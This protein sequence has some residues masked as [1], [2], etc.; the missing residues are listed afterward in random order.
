MFKRKLK[1]PLPPPEWLVVGLGNPGPEYAGTRHNVG[2]EVVELLANEHKI[3]L[4]QRKHRAVYGLGMVGAVS[5]VLVKPMTFMNLSGQAVVQICKHYGIKPAKVMIIA[6]DLDLPV[7]KIRIRGEG[8]PGGHNGHKS[9]SQSLQT[10]EYPRLKIGIG[11]GGETIDHVLSRF[12]PEERVDVNKA[13]EQ[14]AR[15][16]ETVLDS[17]LIAAMNQF[18]GG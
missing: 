8:S 13:V 16:V 17:G 11:K 12:K 15:A 7:G 9:V 5:V 1:E 10:T 4:D 14:S 18:N 6:D 2:F 3:K